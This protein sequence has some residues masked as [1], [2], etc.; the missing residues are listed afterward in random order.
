MDTSVL[1]LECGYGLD[2]VLF[3]R[4]PG[5][6]WKE[7]DTISLY[8]AYNNAKLEYQSLIR[9]GVQ[10]LVVQNA[11]TAS[12]TLYQAYFL[13][14]RVLGGR[15][16]TALAVLETAM[17]PHLGGTPRDEKSTITI[18]PATKSETGEITQVAHLMIGS[19]TFLV[20]S[21]YSWSGYLHA[22]AKDETDRVSQL[23]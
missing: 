7:L 23:K 21:S 8:D 18:E 4:E 17:E 11:A 19:R 15:F 5:A 3:G 13:V 1:R 14:F 20:R 9:P 16:M 12:G 22:F 10:E 2:L 6:A